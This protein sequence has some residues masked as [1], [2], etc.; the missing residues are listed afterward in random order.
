MSFDVSFTKDE[1]SDVKWWRGRK[2]AVWGAGLSGVSAAKLLHRLGAEVTLSDP[3]PIEALP[4][5]QDLPKEMKTSFGVPN[6]LNEAEVLIPSPGLKPSHPLIQRA[7]ASQVQIMSE[8]ELGARLTQA[9]LIAVTGTDG[10]STTTRL[11][12]EAIKAQGLWVRSVGNIGDPL[13]NWALDAPNDGFFALEISAFQLWSTHYLGAEVGV[14]TNI[15]EDHLDYFDGSSIAYRDAKLKLAELLKIGGKLFYPS[16]RF[17]ADEIERERLIRNQSI[18]WVSYE[19]PHEEIE[20]PLIGEHNQL[21]LSA[22]IG[23]TCSLGLRQ[24]LAREAFKTFAPLPY[25]MTLSRTLRGVRYVNDSKATNVHASLSG[26]NSVKESLIVITGGYDKGLD[27]EP[28]IEALRNRAR[29][30]FCIGQTGPQLHQALSE[31]G[32]RSEDVR[33]LEHAVIAASENAKEGEMVLF[34]PAA[35]SFDQFKNFEERGAIF[36]SLVSRLTV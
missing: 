27:H 8:I 13:C 4:L 3:Q 20:S 32:V 14:V 29:C 24:E 36:D 26:I 23:V 11:I 25:R 35:S 21:N 15:A 33:T 18:E 34:S 30:V 17:T 31:K 5:T 1:C 7:I 2:V 9:K 28:L 10:K 22:A 6:E 19:R 16:E 12:E